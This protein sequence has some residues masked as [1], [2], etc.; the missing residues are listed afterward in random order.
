MI[1]LL[2]QSPLTFLLLAGA[3][4]VSICIHEFSHAFVADK[5]GD[6]TAR[7]LGRLT[8]NPK[9]HLDPIGTVFLLLVGF[10][11][12]R[13]V[14]FNP[15]N[16][17]NPKRDAALISLAGPAS[18]FILAIILSFPLRYFGMN[19][20]FGVFLGLTVLYN[21]TLGFF[22]LI[23][24]GPLDGNKVVYGFLPYSLASQWEDLQRYGTYI[25]LFL[26]I[27]NSLEKI[28][29]PLVGATMKLLGVY[30][31]Y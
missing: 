4:I 19:S 29:T 15:L 13:P 27:T 26:V 30:L 7:Y 22:N 5:L 10:G 31:P 25:L 14:P 8:L 18:N 6:P 23:P 28:L 24:F 21:L 16:L 9:A 20:L 2:F 17:R 11:W 1:S 3:L 12:G